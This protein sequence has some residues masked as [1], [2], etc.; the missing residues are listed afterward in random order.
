M[1]RAVRLGVVAVAAGL[2]GGCL[3]I[4]Q[5]TPAAV[6][7]TVTSAYGTVRFARTNLVADDNREV[8]CPHRRR[9]GN[10]VAVRP[11]PGAVSTRRVGVI[12][13]WSGGEH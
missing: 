9:P 1:A 10:E 5:D 12:R 4:Q 6:C 11:G 8:I 13:G 7:I 2:T 3:V